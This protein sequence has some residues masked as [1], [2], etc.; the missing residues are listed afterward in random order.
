MTAVITANVVAPSEEA[1]WIPDTSSFENQSSVSNYLGH[2]QIYHSTP[3]SSKKR[4][5]CIYRF[6]EHPK[7]EFRIFL[8]INS[9]RFQNCAPL[10][11]Y[12]ASSGN[13]LPTFRDNLSVQS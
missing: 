1:D 13:S 9:G 8:R 7:A 6:L 4:S 2:K 12:A 11:Y 3:F 5:Y 10:G